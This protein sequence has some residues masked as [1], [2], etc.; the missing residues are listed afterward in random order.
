VRNLSAKVITMES[1]FIPVAVVLRN[2][3]SKRSSD[4]FLEI[5]GWIECL[6][7][8]IPNTSRDEN[9]MQLKVALSVKQPDAA[10]SV[11]RIW[12]ISNDRVKATGGR[13]AILKKAY[14]ISGRPEGAALSLVLKM[15]AHNVDVSHM[16]LI[17]HTDRRSP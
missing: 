16:R 13:T 12:D 7:R 5:N 14:A 1:T 9:D 15:C 2:P 6:V 3:L 17:A 8:P 10:S 4:R 11:G